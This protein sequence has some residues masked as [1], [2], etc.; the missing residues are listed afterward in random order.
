MTKDT[1]HSFDTCPLRS[2]SLLIVQH[3]QQVIVTA[4]DEVFDML[5]Y[6]ADQLISQPLSVLSLSTLHQKTRQVV[7]TRHA[8]TKQWIQLEVC[9]HHDPFSTA[10]GLDYC[11]IAA[12]SNK[13]QPQP[14]PLS[15]VTL[16]GLNAYGSIVHAYPASEFPHPSSCDLVGRPIMSFIHTDDVRPLCRLLRKSTTHPL[17]PSSTKD[18]YTMD[19]RWLR[20]TRLAT[21]T[22]DTI[23]ESEF[24]WMHITIV[25]PTIYSHVPAL[26]GRPICLLRPSSCS[27][28]SSFSALD[29][30]GAALENGRIYC[31]EF[32]Q[33]LLACLV[34]LIHDLAV[35]SPPEQPLPSTQLTHYLSPPPQHIKVMDGTSI[36]HIPLSSSSFTYSNDSIFYLFS[37]TFLS[38]TMPTSFSPNRSLLD[39]LKPILPQT[40]SHS[41]SL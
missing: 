14:Q 24:E 15:T 7:K 5:G 21:T 41:S 38:Y 2:S 6:H 28:V 16:V 32:L 25:N 13:P 4:S 11:L 22:V 34:Q 30:L 35:A 9:V 1:C 12:K 26:N 33:H 39:L 10:S 31:M 37:S 3:D 18:D 36:R 40:K 19:V 17:P 20:S 23:H 8:I 27:S 29:S